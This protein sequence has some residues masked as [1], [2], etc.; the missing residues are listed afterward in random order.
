MNTQKNDFYVKAVW[1]EEAKVFYTDSNIKGLHIE[2]KTLKKFWNL[3]NQFS[4][5]L[6]FGNHFI[7]K[8]FQN[9]SPPK[10]RKTFTLQPIV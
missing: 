1:D 9:D 2:A 10:L 3:V 6:I 5:E 4:P 7:K 8:D